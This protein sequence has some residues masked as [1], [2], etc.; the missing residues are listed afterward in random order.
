MSRFRN[1]HGFWRSTRV[2]A[3]TAVLATLGVG[4]PPNSEL[5]DIEVTILRAVDR[6]G[7]SCPITNVSWQLDPISVP[8]RPSG[9]TIGTTAR[10]AAFTNYSGGSGT[11]RQGTS[12]FPIVC[13]HTAKH[14]ALAPG[15]WA[16]TG[17]AVRGNAFTCNKVVRA[18]ETTTSAT[19]VFNQGGTAESCS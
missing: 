10:P 8:P 18:N 13:V 2:A 6:E 12:Q 16:I 3:A 4:C 15:T 7:Q 19:W 9:S 14:S 11:T 17:K 1:H 5:G